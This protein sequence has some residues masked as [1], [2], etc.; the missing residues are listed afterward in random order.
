[1]SVVTILLVVR[2]AFLAGLS[3]RGLRALRPVLAPALVRAL[4]AHCVVMLSLILYDYLSLEHRR[5]R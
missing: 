1:M 2:L 3:Y 5:R 4:L